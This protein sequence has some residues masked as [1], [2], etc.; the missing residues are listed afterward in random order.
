MTDEEFL[1]AFEQCTLPEKEWTHRAHVRMAWIYL[2]RG[3]LAAMLPVVRRG[4]QRYNATLNKH[5]GYHEMITRGFV[6]LI[7]DRIGRGAGG[8][9]FESFCAE[10][11]DLLDN[12]LTALL[13]HYRRETLFS[14][15]ARE[16]FVT[17]DLRPLPGA[18]F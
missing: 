10:N 15:A 13:A 5:L 14:P 2:R 7:A 17:P 3:S 12:K 18:N 6:I 9:S 16:G 1:A 8:M 4:I 11:P